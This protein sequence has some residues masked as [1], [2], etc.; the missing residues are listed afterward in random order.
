MFGAPKSPLSAY[1]QIGIQTDVQTANPHQLI[2]LLFDGA[3][4]AINVA[5]SAMEQ[6]TI[7]TKGTSI[8]KA[9]DIIRN[10]LQVSVSSGD[11]GDLAEKLIALYEYMTR[12]LLHANLHNDTGA[13]EEVSS[14]LGELRGAW[15]EIA[16]YPSVNE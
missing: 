7:E 15:V 3:L 11:G 14:L 1:S 16:A 6:K 2:V 8:S 4:S 9:I 13:L 5:K 12:R 10:G